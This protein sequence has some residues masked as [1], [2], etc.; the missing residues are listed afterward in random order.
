MLRGLEILAADDLPNGRTQTQLMY[1]MLAVGLLAGLLVGAAWWSA[2]RRRR[3]AHDAEARERRRLARPVVGQDAW[4]EA[5]DRAK[6][7]SA[8]ELEKQFP[9]EPPKGGTP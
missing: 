1:G 6:T 3:R 5:A 2:I 7:P 9:P 4:A 8:R